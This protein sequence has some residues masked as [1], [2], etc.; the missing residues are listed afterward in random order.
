[1]ASHARPSFAEGAGARRRLAPFS[2]RCPCLLPT[3]TM[4][5]CSSLPRSRHQPAPCLEPLACAP[6]DRVRRCAWEATWLTWSARFGKTILTRIYTVY[7]LSW[8]NLTY[9]ILNQ[10]LC[11]L[12]PTQPN[13]LQP[14]NQTH[15]NN[16]SYRPIIQRIRDGSGERR[17]EL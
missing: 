11:Q 5:P 17:G 13:P 9:C 16:F 7:F 1:M 8:T 15:P 10:T 2:D 6:I 4:P 12:G 3:P 14:S